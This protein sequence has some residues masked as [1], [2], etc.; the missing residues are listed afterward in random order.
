MNDGDEKDYNDRVLAISE[1]CI[2][3]SKLLKLYNFSHNKESIIKYV[4][5]LT[6]DAII[7]KKIKCVKS[8]ENLSMRLEEEIKESEYKKP[9]ITLSEEYKELS[10]ILKENKINYSRLR[11]T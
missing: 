11:G 1:T 8:L 2:I 3:Q 10:S 9:K 4:F 7:K 5:P 6:R